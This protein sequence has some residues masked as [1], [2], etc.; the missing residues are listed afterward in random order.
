MGYQSVEPTK[1]TLFVSELLV[2]Q[3][4][5]ENVNFNFQ[6]YVN[7]NNLTKNI[8]F[9]FTTLLSQIF[10]QFQVLSFSAW[11][12]YFFCL[13]IFLSSKKNWAIFWSESK[14]TMLQW[15]NWLWRRIPIPQCKFKLNFLQERLNWPQRAKLVSI[16]KMNKMEI[17]LL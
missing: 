13:E 5:D 8:L 12:K 7:K 14:S 16:L 1:Q 10:N 17:V 2:L 3:H 6:D 4:D 11:G 15:E 9:E